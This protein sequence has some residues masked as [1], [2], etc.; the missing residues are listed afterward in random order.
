MS[1]IRLNVS[2][3][4]IEFTTPQWATKYLFHAIIS[5]PFRHLERQRRNIQLKA[6]SYSI[7]QSSWL[8]F[9]CEIQYS[10]YKQHTFEGFSYISALVNTG[11]MSGSQSHGHPPINILSSNYFRYGTSVYQNLYYGESNGSSQE[12]TNESTGVENRGDSTVSTE[13][14]R[15]GS[16]IKR[17]YKSLLQ[18]YGGNPSAKAKRLI[19]K[20]HEHGS[21]DSFSI[22]SLRSS[23]SNR[24]LPSGHSR[25]AMPGAGPQHAAISEEQRAYAT[26]NALPVEILSL[27]ISNFAAG[28]CLDDMRTLV[29]CLYVNKKFYE[30]AKIVLYDSPTFI[31]TY[32]TAQFVTNLRLH[33]ENGLL[34]RCLDLSKLKNGVIEGSAGQFDEDDNEE[35]IRISSHRGNTAEDVLEETNEEDGE[36]EINNS[37]DAGLERAATPVDDDL[38]D[39]AWAGWRDWRYRFD[40]LYGNQMLSC[41]KSLKRVSSRSSSVHSTGTGGAG[42]VPAY[43]LRKAHRSNSSV[44]SFTSSIMSTFYNS[45]SFSSLN[46]LTTH[47]SGS[48]DSSS[49]WFSKLFSSKRTPKQKY[50]SYVKNKIRRNEST[51]TLPIGEELSRTSVKF[52]IESNPKTQPYHER[53]PYTNKYLLKH[54]LSKDLPLGYVLHLIRSCPNMKSL[55]LAN[56]NISQDFEVQSRQESSANRAASLIPHVAESTT[57]SEDLEGKSLVPIYLTDSSKSYAYYE[58]TI[59]PSAKRLE[60][61]H[62]GSPYAMHGESWITSNYPPPIDERT[63]FR[64]QRS[65]KGPQCTYTLTKL[66]VQNLFALIYHSL[67]M[68]S[69]LSMD[70]VVWCSQ[71]DVKS[72]IFSSLARKPALHVSFIHAGMSRN[73]S[74][75]SN[76]LLC[77]FVAIL[78]LAE[79]LDRDDLFLED[80]FNVRTERFHSDGA[81]H[82]PLLV[83]RSNPITV[84]TYDKEEIRCTLQIRRS[85]RMAVK[86]TLDNENRILCDI[87]L[88][89]RSSGSDAS[90]VRIEELAFQL[91]GRLDDLRAADLRRHIGENQYT[92]H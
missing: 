18:N 74:W 82:D 92:L 2:T 38:P 55:N 71:A 54:A 59:G 73:M 24:N 44:S 25:S 33:P 80:L 63:K 4:L 20:F 47:D 40:P 32:R 36:Q 49:K 78:S 8:E 37:V 31:S 27:I 77:H 14:D 50:Q 45:P 61:L 65:R 5:H 34:V 29:R 75:A 68:L 43:G 28:A 35:D 60:E 30:A 16:K 13:S 76:G 22:F 81:D 26:I 90:I 86:T 56:V 53:H 12:S 89:L 88:G 66:E 62:I 64:T 42:T 83:A 79:I 11:S 70:N 58:G 69:T 41:H 51:E 46:L 85:S 17:R 1:V 52:S 7:A 3:Q 39:I 84:T 23:Y 87:A 19:G 91:I 6:L 21:S 48:E 72:F 57:D 9:D 10:L 67:P 15:G